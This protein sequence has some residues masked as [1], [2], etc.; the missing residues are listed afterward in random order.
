MGRKKKKFKPIIFCYYCD[1]TFE[2][3]KVLI[4]HQR[5]KHFKC[6]VCHKRLGSAHGMMVH[7]FQVHKQQIDKVPH[8]KEGRDSFHIDIFG[9]S[10]IPQQVID[11]KHAERGEPP[12]KRQKINNQ[13]KNPL[14]I[15]NNIHQQQTQQTITHP[16]FTNPIISPMMN[17]MMIN[18]MMINPMMK[19]MPPPPLPHPPFTNPYINHGINH[20][21]N[22]G[23]NH[24]VPPPHHHHHQQQQQQQQQQITTHQQSPIQTTN[25][26]NINKKKK[27]ITEEHTTEH[28]T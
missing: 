7:V 8:A 22:H 14:I 28:Q 10:N 26:N 12:N 25:G 15:D 4:Q 23:I 19:P 2:N 18:P 20:T 27:K 6:I 11:E 1:R 16:I 17:Q 13:Q 3:E 24:H 21:I 5:A 9:M